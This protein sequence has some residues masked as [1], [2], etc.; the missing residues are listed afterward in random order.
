M[1]RTMKRAVLLVLL[2]A[3]QSG[4]AD[5][6]PPRPGGG[7]TIIIGGGGGSGGRDAGIDGDGDGGTGSKIAGRVCILGDLRQLTVCDTT[8]DASRLTVRLGTRSATAPAR[9]GEFEIAGPLGNGLTW[10]VT[11]ATVVTSVMPFGTDNTIPVIPDDLYTELLNVNQVIFPNE[12]QGSVVVRVVSGV[13]PA[14]G[15]TATSTLVS[16][17]V[18]PRYDD[19]ASLLDWRE[20]GPTDRFGVVWFPGVQVTTTPAQITLRPPTG[21]PVT[22]RASVVEQ[23][24]TF[25]TQDLQ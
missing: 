20:V 21:T 3:C 22:L 18:I 7:G 5:D 2:A 4:A 10:V 24:I 8:K 6:Y 16:D 9:T 14:A 15:V 19:P 11:G 25:V 17:N 1:L 13:E 12:G 23:A